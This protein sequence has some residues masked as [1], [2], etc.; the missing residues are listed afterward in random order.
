MV[1]LADIASDDEAQLIMAADKIVQLAK[2]RD[3]EGFIAS[4]VQ[5]RK[6]F[7]SDRSRTAAIAAHTNAFKV[8][9]DVVI[10]LEKLAEYTLGIERINII[11]SIK[12]KLKIIAA[13]SDYLHTDIKINNDSI[14]GEA[15]EFEGSAETQHILEDKKQ[16]ALKLVTTVQTEWNL[17]LNNLTHWLLILMPLVV[18]VV[19]KVYRLYL[20]LNPLLTYLD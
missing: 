12:N 9:E 6:Y 11:L 20:N 2:A 1:L 4:S 17:I 10:P 16:A 3:A 14:Q 15:F 5:A 13:V 8:N 7:W 19:M 18:I